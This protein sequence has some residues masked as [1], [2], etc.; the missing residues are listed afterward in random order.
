MSELRHG[1]ALQSLPMPLQSGQAISIARLKSPPPN[2]S[3]ADSRAHRWRPT[4]NR[5]CRLL[6]S[7]R[8]PGTILTPGTDE[9]S[10]AEQQLMRPAARANG[11]G[12]RRTPESSRVSRRVC[13][14]PPG[15][16]GSD[17][18]RRR[19]RFGCAVHPA[20]DRFPACRPDT[21]RLKPL[22]GDTRAPFAAQGDTV[23]R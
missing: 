6:C 2:F 4:R 8:E 17:M 5:G 20:T 18:T 13:C 11:Q 16:G 14:H 21:C 23:A 15:S 19:G 10:K 22:T 7:Q 1:A 12:R 9:C 3:S